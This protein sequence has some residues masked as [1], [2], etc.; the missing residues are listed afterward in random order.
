[1]S[2]PGLPLHVARYWSRQVK[3]EDEVSIYVCIW[4]Q[5]VF[6]GSLFSADPAFDL[7]QWRAAVWAAADAAAAVAAGPVT[8]GAQPLDLFDLI[9]PRLFLR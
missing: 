6:G 1:M 8:S 2:P 9:S 7:R 5:Q 4:S 3:G